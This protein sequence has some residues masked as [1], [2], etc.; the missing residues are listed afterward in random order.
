MVEVGRLGEDVESCVV[1]KLHS[2]AQTPLHVG[3]LSNC[4]IM[5]ATCELS[6]ARLHDQTH[7]LGKKYR[8]Q[9]GCI[10][11]EHLAFEP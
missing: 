6:S 7:V 2:C 8:P 5:C 11:D 3:E 9:S 4:K 1:G 10:R